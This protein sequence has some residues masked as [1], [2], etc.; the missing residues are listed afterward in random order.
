MSEICD[1]CNKEIK[2][3]RRVKTKIITG[4]LQEIK[5]RSIS[6]PIICNYCGGS[7][8]NEHR[9]PPNHKCS[10]LEDWES[11]NPIKLGGYTAT[12]STD[13]IRYPYT[14]PSKIPCQ[15]PELPKASKIRQ[16]PLTKIS[17]YEP[18]KD[19][20]IFSKHSIL[21]ILF[22]IIILILL[23]LLSPK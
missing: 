18:A 8:C 5:D 19:D 20:D 4:G 9:L 23:W 1:F 13:S 10:G 6:T 2:P 11:R 3:T 16:M 14:M 17:P 12:S 7:F 15:I 22:S 21:F